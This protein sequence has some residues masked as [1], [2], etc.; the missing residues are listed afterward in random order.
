MRLED[1]KKHKELNGVERS[2][3]VISL[4]VMDQGLPRGVTSGAPGRSYYQREP[5]VF[6]ALLAS[7]REESRA[8]GLRSE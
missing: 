4:D 3:D 6:G 7:V 1:K 2:G 8:L 5:L